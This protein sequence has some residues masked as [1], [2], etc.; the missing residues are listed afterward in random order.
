[1]T[2][3]T[4]LLKGN[5]RLFH[6]HIYIIVIGQSK[7][8]QIYVLYNYDFSF[9]LQIMVFNIELQ[10]HKSLLQVERYTDGLDE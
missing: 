3:L 6:I 1:M 7:T 2:I 5:N 4:S 10:A 9:A 8:Q